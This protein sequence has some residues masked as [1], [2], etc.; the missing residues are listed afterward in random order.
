MKLIGIQKYLALYN[1]EEYLFSYVG[2]E[3]KKRGFMKFDEFYKIAMWKSVRQKQK[4][5]NNKKIIKKYTKEAFFENSELIKIKKLCSLDGVAIPTASA[6]LTIVYPDKYG[7]IDV[8]CLG[9]L[10]K[11]GFEIKTVA[12]PKNWLRYLGIIRDLSSQNNISP[13]EVDKVLFSMHKEMLEN[14]NHKNLYRFNSK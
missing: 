14:D 7:I 2:P 6:I 8:R 9:M 10:K 1:Q 13:R 4:Y 5:L 12:S 3:V 11:L